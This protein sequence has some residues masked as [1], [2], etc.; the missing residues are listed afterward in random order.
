MKKPLRAKYFHFH[1]NYRPPYYGT[2]RKASRVITGRRPLALSHS[3]SG[4]HLHNL[5]SS[6]QE[7]H[8]D[9]DSNAEW[10]EE[11]VEAGEDC[12]SDVEEGI[13]SQPS[14]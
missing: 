7:L 10:E 2:W 14:L 6:A 13:V 5:P 12:L 8:Y 9:I 11:Q 4:F 3:V 1:D